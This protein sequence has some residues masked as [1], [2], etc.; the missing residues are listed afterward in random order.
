MQDDILTKIYNELR[1]SNDFK[2]VE[3]A[4][5]SYDPIEFIDALNMSAESA[6]KILY[7]VCLLRADIKD[8]AAIY[9]AS[10]GVEAQ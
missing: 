5:K 3:L 9:L 7:Y 6:R 2:V 8:K 4:S 1:L 10:L